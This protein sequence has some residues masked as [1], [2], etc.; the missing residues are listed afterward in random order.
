MLQAFRIKH[1]LKLN[2][3]FGLLVLYAC[4]SI[5]GGLAYYISLFLQNADGFSTL[6]IATI[7]SG[8]SIGNIVGSYLG[9]IISDKKN[10][11][12]SLKLGLFIQGSSLLQLIFVHNLFGVSLLMFL[13][14]AGSYLYVV[15]S[16]YILNLKFDRAGDR[17]KIISTQ[18][19]VSNAGISI[20]AVLIGYAT[21]GYYFYIF[22]ISS[23]VLVSISLCIKPID[24]EYFYIASEQPDSNTTN[25]GETINYFFIFGL[26]SMFV[27]GTLF[28][29]H[30]TLY[31]LYLNLQYNEIIIGYILA[32]N[33]ILIILFQPLVINKSRSY[34]E[35]HCLI[36]GIFVIGLSFIVLSLGLQLLSLLVATLMY[37]FGEMLGTTYAQSLVFAH[38]KKEKK[39]RALGLYK[40][41]YSI[42]KIFGAYMV[43]YNFTYYGYYYIWLGCGILGI[44]T[45]MV[46]LISTFSNKNQEQLIPTP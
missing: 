16:N 37:T 21:V 4:Q 25:F 13:M 14:G 44:A 9:G 5:V 45:A 46:I 39:G 41:I 23:I 33:P 35:I 19:V 3:T 10:P 15:S 27:M 36:L 22:F 7:I 2:T 32:M 6:Q 42:S 18:H 17:S 38:A 12:V 1:K 26:L 28:S 40:I 20:A 30:R 34:Q 8:A 11:Y 43:G 31:S 24:R 29:S